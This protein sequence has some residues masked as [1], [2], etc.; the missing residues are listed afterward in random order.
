MGRSNLPAGPR[1]LLLLTSP[2][3]PT[4]ATKP[5]QTPLATAWGR[6][7]APLWHP[8]VDGTLRGQVGATKLGTSGKVFPSPAPLFPTSWWDHPQH[9][10]P[11][12]AIRDHG[13]WAQRVPL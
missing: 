3:S 8:T 5:C 12:P 13:V 4:A 10:F 2:S 6:A 11:L 7:G 1:A 9:P